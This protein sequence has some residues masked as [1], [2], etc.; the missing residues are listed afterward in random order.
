M[1]EVFGEGYAAAYDEIYREKDYESECDTVE[2]LW[3]RHG[4]GDVQSVLDLGCGTGNHLLPLARRGYSVAGVDV[5]R[6]MLANAQAKARTDDLD[7]N[8]VEGDVRSIEL[9]RTFDAVIMMFAVLGYQTTNDD[10]SRAL[11]TVRR[12]LGHDGL[13]AFD[14]WYG[15]AVL[16][17]RPSD[18]VR[19]WTRGNVQLLR[20]ASGEI[21]SRRHLCR[22][23]YRLWRIDRGGGCESTCEEHVMRYFFPLELELFLSN[24]GMQLLGLSAFSELGRDPDEATW[25]VMGLA[26]AI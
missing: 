25:N 18:R 21:D 8:L 15:P 14:C 20:A 17:Q 19:E 16:S 11:G 13:F 3:R 1:T 9:G 23:R 22:V 5:S 26:K 2:D 6:D 7:V 10:V 24:S 4:G 12:H